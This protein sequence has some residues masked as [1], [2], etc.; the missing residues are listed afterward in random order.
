V[1]TTATET[2]GPS[3]ADL[4]DQL[5]TAE[6]IIERLTE[7]LRDVELAREDE[8]WKRIGEWAESMLTREG[9]RN[10]A[11]L[12]RAFVVANPLA[13]R[14]VSL[15]T[16]Y[17]WGQGVQIGARAKGPT[18]DAP[19]AQDVNAV[20]QTW[21][22]DPEVSR[23][24][25]SAGAHERNERGLATDGNMFTAL[26]TNPL[27]G[28][29]RPRVIPVD[30]IVKPVC[31]P[32]DQLDRWFWLREYVV[33]IAEEG[34]R[35][36]TIRT[37]TETRRVL[38][39]SIDY[40]P[41]QKPARFDGI[42]IA[43]DSPVAELHVN[44]LHGQDFGVGDLFSVLP[45]IRSYGGFLTDWAKLTKALSRIAF[46]SSSSNKSR[47]QRA[48]TEVARTAASATPE[49][50]PKP[51]GAN[52]LHESNA[53]GTLV[54]DSGTRLEAVSKSGATIDANSG[55]PLAAMVAAGTDLPVTMLLADPGVTGAR[56]TAETLDKPTE[57][58]ATMRR[59]LWS[60]YLRRILSY[61]VDMSA[62]APYGALKRK[63]LTRDR[64]TGREVIVLAGDTD[65]T[66]EV[67]WPDLTETPLK[68]L[69]EAIAKA[70]ST[71]T[72]PKVEI[73][74][75]LIRALNI[76]DGDEIIDS[77]TDDQ[78]RWIG[79]DD[80]GTAAADRFNNG[81]DPADTFR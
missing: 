35:A 9:H 20:I 41:A 38:Y 58:M 57:L 62:K 45:W 64:S 18:L 79:G 75:Q 28:W 2:T 34:T 29:V 74:K 19:Q 36:G 60:D 27:T 78:G 3:T 61:V 55:R 47:A 66:I 69:I 68:D 59:D 13:K 10:S 53:G 73:L 24:L 81:D 54:T 5:D 56:A 12:A 7:S 33:K 49:G 30:E 39:P 37:R 25:T 32:E 17:V 40:R 76:K 65:R 42:P 23:V 1:T 6:H 44:D 26:V 11:R 22:E 63:S 50:L 52:G 51:R 72:L 70:D 43:W 80:A 77:A 67:T 8:G 21:L 48:A 16:A 71:D 46:Q 31:N 4:T 14:A 15:R